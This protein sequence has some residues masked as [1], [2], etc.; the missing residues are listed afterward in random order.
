MESRNAII[1]RTLFCAVQHCDGGCRGVVFAQRQSIQGLGKEPRRSKRGPLGATIPALT[2]C[3]SRSELWPLSWHYA[4]SV[5]Q[6]LAHGRSQ[7]QSRSDYPP[8][9]SRHWTKTLSRAVT[10]ISTHCLSPDMERLPSRPITRTTIPGFIRR[11]R[12]HPA[13]WW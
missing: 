12:P 10:D 13:H 5:R 11:K 3:L 9:S 4:W 6:P 1:K 7:L 8:L 2:C